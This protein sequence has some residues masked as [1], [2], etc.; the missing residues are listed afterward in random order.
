MPDEPYP[1]TIEVIYNETIRQYDLLVNSLDGLNNKSIGIIAFNGTLLS[2]S[3]LSIVQI[4]KETT[5]NLQIF[6]FTIAIFYILILISI[7]FAAIAYRVV[8]IQTVNP[9]IL[10][11]E[12]YLDKRK[13]F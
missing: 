8:T 4:I 5:S 6:L 11:E 2:L 9:H 7:T 12:Y 10:H 3:S 1:E 13:M